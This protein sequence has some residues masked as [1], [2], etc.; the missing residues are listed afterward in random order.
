MPVDNNRYVRLSRH[1]LQ[2]RLLVPLQQQKQQHD[3]HLLQPELRA[4]SSSDVVNF[5]HRFVWHHLLN[6]RQKQDSQQQRQNRIYLAS[7]N[8]CHPIK[9]WRTPWVR[10]LPRPRS[11]QPDRL[12]NAHRQLVN[13]PRQILTQQYKARE[14]A[15]VT[16]TNSKAGVSVEFVCLS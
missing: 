2:L 10:R 3:K 13:A 11:R 15:A 14:I 16:F 8:V 12:A 7:R 5:N 1:F 4:A 9:M 6:V